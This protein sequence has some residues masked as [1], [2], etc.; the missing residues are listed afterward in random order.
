MDKGCNNAVIGMGKPIKD[1][2][3]EEAILFERSVQV[4][5]ENVHGNGQGDPQTHQP[6]IWTGRRM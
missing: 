4:T 6:K 1:S 3:S 5:Y 2:D